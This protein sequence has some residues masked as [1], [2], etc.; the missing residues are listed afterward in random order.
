MQITPNSSK[1]YFEIMAL[2]EKDITFY[3]EWFGQN[4]QL[5]GK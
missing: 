4:T 1:K 2:N 5:I 3:L